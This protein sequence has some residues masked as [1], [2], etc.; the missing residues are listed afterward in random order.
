MGK[1]RWMTFVSYAQNFEDVM[2][3]RAL[4]HVPAGFYI[5]AGAQHP[6]EDSVTR[7][8]Y[9]RGWSGINVEPVPAYARRLQAARWR[10]TTLAVA[11]GSTP[12]HA[13]L[14]VVENTGLSTL[15]RETAGRHRAD[16]RT[17]HEVPVVV[18]TL[19]AICQRH[20]RGPVHFLKIDVEGAERAV[21]EGADFATFRPWIVL[22]EA[23]APNS[24]VETHA[25]WEGLLLAAGYGFAWFD[26]LNRFYVADE[27]AAA[28]LPHF[29]VPPNVFDDFMR[30]ADTAF[31]LRAGAAEAEAAR[32][33]E[34]L[35]TA[36][37]REGRAA[38]EASEARIL[39]DLRGQELARHG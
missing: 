33:R 29:R 15:D 35:A 17:V 12:G 25:E 21:L 16:G 37:E 19:A 13:V 34:R 20:V 39:S 18:D 27:H 4:R 11:L 1:H 32:L 36:E 30:G 23:T 28:L 22:L 24:T 26:G 3:W 7:A 14:Q 10:D 8:F 31:A 6:D 38:F 9:E 5:D 2:L